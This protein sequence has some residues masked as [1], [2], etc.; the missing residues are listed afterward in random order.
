MKYFHIIRFLLTHDL[1]FLKECW[2]VEFIK[3]EF[4]WRRLL[5][6]MWRKEN[7]Y[8]V[9][10]RLASEMAKYGNKKQKKIAYKINNFL[11]IKYTVEIGLENTFIDVGFFIG[12]FASIVLFDNVRAGKNFQI[13]QCTTIGAKDR[14][15]MFTFGDNVNIGCGTSIIGGKIKIGS[16]VMIGAMSFINKDIPDNCTVYTEKTN[17]IIMK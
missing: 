12:H 4:K 5:K 14:D 1:T 16:N 6:K 15:A 17:K 9:W 2:E 10:W 7:T 13:R 11:K 8:I 3:K